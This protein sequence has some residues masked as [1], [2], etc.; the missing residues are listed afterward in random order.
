MHGNVRYHMHTLYCICTAANDTRIV[1]MYLTMSHRGDAEL[2]RK[3]RKMTNINFQSLQNQLTS[4]FVLMYFNL[5]K[6]S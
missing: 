1:D 6:F 4:L 2:V 5:S 3:V